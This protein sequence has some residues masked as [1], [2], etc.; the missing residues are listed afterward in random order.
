MP[1]MRYHLYLQKYLLSADKA[2]MRVQTVKRPKKFSGFV[3]LLAHYVGQIKS[4]LAV[5]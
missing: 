1:A 5:R 3:G 2:F 4:D